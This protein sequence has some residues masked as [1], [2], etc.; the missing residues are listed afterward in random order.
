[1][2]LATAK[3]ARTAQKTPQLKSSIGH[4][5]S[6]AISRRSNFPQGKLNPTAEKKGTLNLISSGASSRVSKFSAGV[7]TS[8]D[9]DI[10]ISG[11]FSVPVTSQ[12]E[13]LISF[14]TKQPVVDLS[15]SPWPTK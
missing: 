13:F 6:V 2:P 5:S 4:F 12:R 8:S 7:A 15:V 3:A 11:S 14:N 9:K 1:M 10:R